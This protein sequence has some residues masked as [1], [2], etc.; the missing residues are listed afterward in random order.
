MSTN[1]DQIKQRNL[2]RYNM[3]CDI[4]YNGPKRRTQIAEKLSIRKSSITSIAEELIRQNWLTNIDT[5]HPRSPLC[6]NKKKCCLA[7]SHE[8]TKLRAGLYTL[9]GKLFK[10]SKVSLHKNMTYDDFLYETNLLCSQ[11]LHKS[12]S[13]AL[14]V[15][16]ALPGIID[17]TNNNVLHSASAPQLSHKNL[18]DDL[19]HILKLPCLIEND[20]R[21][22]LMGALWFEPK[23]HNL[24]NAIYIDIT[25]GVSTALLVNGT[26]HKGFNN[27]A[28]EIGHIKAGDQ[29]RKCHCGKIDC[30]ETYI[31]IPALAKTVE[32]NGFFSIDELIQKLQPQQLENGLNS[33]ANILRPLIAAIDPEII[34]LGNQEPNFY[35]LCMPILKKLLKTNINLEIVSDSNSSALTG[36]AS[37]ILNAIF[38]N[39]HQLLH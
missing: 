22:S 24:Q 26:L 4:F 10:T 1:N 32:L 7:L 38:A 6:F 39:T 13:K 9:D 36:I 21:A 19:S 28:G 8:T 15:G 5:A 25:E 27:A 18:G 11:I 30:L 23:W 12:K 34:L 16:I 2:N 29:N 17:S 37:K 20:V 3:L 35:K 14:M 31:S 33:L